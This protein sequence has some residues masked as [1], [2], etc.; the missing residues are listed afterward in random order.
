MSKLVA[1][2]KPLS[3]KP[4]RSSAL[5]E[6]DMF[7]NTF[8]L[9]PALKDELD[10]KG[11]AYRFA[12][13]KELYANQGYHK[14]GWK[15]F[16]RDKATSDTIGN[17]DFLNGDDPEGVIRRGDAILVVKSVEDH[18]KHRS[19]LDQKAQ[20]LKAAT[21]KRHAEDMREVAREHGIRTQVVEGYEEDGS[22]GDEE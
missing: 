18:Q 22:E 2:R 5:L 14:R 15:V 9:D 21:G 4:K 6:G 16:K 7:G 19:F 20:R 13:A 12:S 17:R 11:L 10:K 3:Q 1:G 8:S